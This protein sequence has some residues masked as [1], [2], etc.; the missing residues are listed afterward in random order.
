MAER[1]LKGRGKMATKATL[2]RATALGLITLGAFPH[3]EHV[4]SRTDLCSVENAILPDEPAPHSPHGPVG[5][6][7]SLTAVSTGP[8]LNAAATLSGQGSMIVDAMVVRSPLTQEK[9]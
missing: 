4:C 7:G 5:S 3:N 6:I 2:F 8:T 1:F 9:H